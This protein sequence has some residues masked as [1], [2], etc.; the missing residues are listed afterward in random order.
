[1]LIKKGYSKKLTRRL[2]CFKNYQKTY[3][4]SQIIKTILTS[5][6]ILM[7]KKKNKFVALIRG[8]CKMIRKS[9]FL[10]CK[11]KVNLVKLNFSY[12]FIFESLV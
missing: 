2:I 5:V 10:I 6:K 9:K 3:Y 4:I 12:F 11:K 7:K 8:C 1:M